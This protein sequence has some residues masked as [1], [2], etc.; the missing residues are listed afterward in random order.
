MV[1]EADDDTFLDRY[2]ATVVVALMTLG[3]GAALAYVPMALFAPIARAV[4]AL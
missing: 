3:L 4:A 1:Q 2:A